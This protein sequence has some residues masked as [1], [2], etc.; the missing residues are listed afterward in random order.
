MNQ[1]R[2]IGSKHVAVQTEQTK[3]RPNWTKKL[4]KTLKASYFSNWR[5][6]LNDKIGKALNKS[7]LDPGEVQSLQGQVCDLKQRAKVPGYR[8]QIHFCVSF[9]R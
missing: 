1:R 2:F 4:N 9:Q 7:N 5:K 6:A 3:S 8:G